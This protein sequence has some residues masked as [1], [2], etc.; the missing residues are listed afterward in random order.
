MIEL[1]L[2]D[3]KLR[4]KADCSNRAAVRCTV[5]SF[6]IKENSDVVSELT[7]VYFAGEIF[8]G[9]AADFDSI[10]IITRRLVSRNTLGVADA[11]STISQARLKIRSIC[12]DF[13]CQ[14]Q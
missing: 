7:R 13:E 5:G 8:F 11:R 1:W 2:C 14:V 3:D 6:L 4:I 10:S 9:I 12:R